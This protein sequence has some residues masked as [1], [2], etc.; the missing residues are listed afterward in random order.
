LQTSLGYT[1]H[2]RVGDM[3]HLRLAGAGFLVFAFD[4]IGTGVRQEEGRDFYDLHPRWSLMGK[5]VLDARHAMDAILANGDAD[6][7]QVYLAGFAMGGMVAALTAALD[8]RVA[9]AV[10]VAGFTPWRS[11][12]AASGT[13]GMGRYSHLY[14]WLPRLGAFVNHESKAPVDFNEVLAAIAPRRAMVVAP[15]VD[16]HETHQDVVRAVEMARQAY[17]L[18]GAGDRLQIQSPDRIM[19]FDNEMQTQVIDWLK[20]P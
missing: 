14:G 13:G 8:E 20:K 17:L 15:T 6:P 2:Y 12:T 9:G 1:P 4:P 5:M 11:D 10:S 19:E 16:W 3:P 7:R 18:L